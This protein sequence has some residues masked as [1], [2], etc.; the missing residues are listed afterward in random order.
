MIYT[1]TYLQL[2]C[3]PRDSYLYR[4]YVPMSD[5][6]LLFIPNPASYVIHFSRTEFSF[7][8]Q[9]IDLRTVPCCLE[10]KSMLGAPGPSSFLNMESFLMCWELFDMF[11]GSI[12]QRYDQ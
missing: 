5:T 4:I 1:F 12:T 3:F 2:I 11:L 6:V 7:F 9:L 8:Q 10:R